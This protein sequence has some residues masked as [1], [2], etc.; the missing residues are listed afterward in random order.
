MIGG[1]ICKE[2]IGRAMIDSSTGSVSEVVLNELWAL[3]FYIGHAWVNEEDTNAYKGQWSE[4]INLK[5]S[6]EPS[7]VGEYLN[8]SHVL[9]ELIG[10]YGRDEAM[11]KL[12]FENNIPESDNESRLSHLKK[13]VVDEF[14]RVYLTVGGFKTFGARNYNSFVG[15]PRGNNP[16]PYRSAGE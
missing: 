2:N 3:F 5:T 1:E 13:F 11:F 8:A 6:S 10:L 15:G 9:Q 16:P 4:F 7:Y 14:I 12:F